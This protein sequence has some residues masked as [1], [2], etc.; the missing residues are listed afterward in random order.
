MGYTAS[1]I[2]LPYRDR[3][4]LESE[5]FPQSLSAH[6]IP[7]STVISALSKWLLLRIAPPFSHALLKP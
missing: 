5:P 2:L 1:E 6:K 7:R 3:K 4:R